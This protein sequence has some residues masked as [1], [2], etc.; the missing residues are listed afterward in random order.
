MAGWQ[1]ATR[2]DLTGFFALNANTNPG[3]RPALPDG[4]AAGYRQTIGNPGAPGVDTVRIVLDLFPGAD[5]AQAAAISL[6]QGYQD[7]GYAAA[8]DATLVGLQATDAALE[9]TDV[10]V[11]PEFAQGTAAKACVFIWQRGNLVLVEIV[12]SAADRSWPLAAAR[13]WVE[14]VLSHAAATAGT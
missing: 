2:P 12:G 4:L 14:D 7:L 6:R 9:G 5:L 10:F 1:T 8:V 11:A 13:P 3:E